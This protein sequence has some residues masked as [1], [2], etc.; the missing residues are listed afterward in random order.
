MSTRWNS[1]FYMLERVLEQQQPLC[2]TL[3]EIRR[4][5]LIPTE[6]EI[7]SMETFV[8]AMRPIAEIT[9]VMGKEKRVSFSAVRLFLYKLLDIHLIEKPTDSNI[10]KGIKQVVKSDL[11][12]RYSDPDLMLLL[13]KAC[14]LDPRFKSLSFLSEKDKKDVII[15]VEEEAAQMAP[16]STTLSEVET[17]GDEPGPSKKSKQDS[18]FL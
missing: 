4:S 11:Q 3:I 8:E 16:T 12:D 14:F 9:E 6:T 5:D 10:M 15:S 18:K 2:A 13:N 1:T 17:S 7:S